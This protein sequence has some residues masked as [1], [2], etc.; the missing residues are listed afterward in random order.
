MTLYID[1]F[2]YLRFYPSELGS[3]DL[4]D[5][6]ASKAYSYYAQGWLGE[7][8][9]HNVETESAYCILKGDSR[10]S[11]KI[12]DTCYRLWVIFEKKSGK[13]RSSHCECFAGMG[14][15]CNHVAAALFRVEAMVRLGLT[16]PACTSM[17]N[18]W[19]PNRTEVSPKKVMDIK[20]DRDD[21]GN[22]GKK[23]RTLL[24]T[25]K[26]IYN[27]LSEN[28]MKLLNLEQIA[29]ALE[30]VSPNSIIHTAVAKPDAVDEIDFVRENVEIKDMTLGIT[31]VDDIL[32][33]STSRQ[34]FKENLE[35]NMKDEN[36]KK[37]QMLTLGQ[38][39]N[40][41]WFTYRKGVI[42]AS[43]S[44]DILSKMKKVKRGGGG[45]INMF[46]TNKKVSGLTY[47]N[48]EIPALKYGREMEDIA[49]NAFLEVMKA[50]HKNV[51]LKKCGLY[52][53][54]V[55]PVIG[56]SPDRIMECSCHPPSCVEIK[57]PFS[58]NFTSPTDE[59]VKLPY[60][61]KNKINRNHSYFTQ[62]MVQMAV[63]QLS[64]TFFV[65][66]TPHGI[67]VDSIQFDAELWKEMKTALLEYYNDFYL[68][69]IYSD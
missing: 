68:R 22:R 11:Q 15:T 4:N 27:P 30:A 18:V 35:A 55:T 20:F 17:S 19:L 8:Q 44:H 43:I 50:E 40:T 7:L 63:T 48:P 16:N 69:T 1:I 53:D 59:S 3:S 51:V 5:Y 54:P 49:A 10:R 65:V 64:T 31:S 33:M 6:K 57:C 61:A 25:P 62:C 39:E 58:I 2:N 66:W 46:Q 9:Y 26:K 24:S 42:T 34:E 56:G 41:L 45:V 60:I 67:L 36:I 32:I 13:V 37:I 38:S 52:L 29:S 14:Q 23:K 47:T 21:F 28:P 12:R